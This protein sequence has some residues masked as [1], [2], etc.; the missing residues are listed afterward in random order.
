MTSAP[1]TEEELA[2][3]LHLTLDEIAHFR[4]TRKWPHLRFGRYK[5]RYTEQQ[6]AQIEA[7]HSQRPPLTA[8]PAIGGQT[9]A[10]KRRAS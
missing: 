7:L 1:I 2:E 8:A 10:S 6:V 4:R 5:V 3:R 9:A